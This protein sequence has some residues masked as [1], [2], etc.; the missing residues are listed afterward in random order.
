MIFAMGTLFR[1]AAGAAFAITLAA[2]NV[3]P[4]PTSRA[5]AMSRA[6]PSSPFSATLYEDTYNSGD[7]VLY[8]LRFEK[9][10]NRPGGGWFVMKKLDGDD[11]H[12]KRP[13]LIWTTPKDLTVVVHTKG[14][15][16][17]TVQNFTNQSGNDGSLTFEY[18]ADGLEQ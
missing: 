4:A 2:C 6:T 11:S 10:E 13:D 8:S 17:R 3:T 5:Q 15:S 1:L 18:R 16:G 7:S 12:P 14:I 9:T